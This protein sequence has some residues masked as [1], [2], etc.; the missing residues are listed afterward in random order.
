MKEKLL[1]KLIELLKVKS[2]IT[3]ISFLTFTYLSISNKV[4]TE[5][6]MLILGMISTYFFSKDVSAKK[7]EEFDEKG[8]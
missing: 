3:I 7:G 2:I 8:N 1:T 4:D 6:F 5:D